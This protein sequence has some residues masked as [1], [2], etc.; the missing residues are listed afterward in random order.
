MSGTMG[1][2]VSLQLHTKEEAFFEAAR[3]GDV[4]R[5]REALAAH[6]NFDVDARGERGRTP[7]LAAARHGHAL[8]VELLLSVGAQPDSAN[9]SG[10]TPLMVRHVHASAAHAALY[11]LASWAC[12]ARPLSPPHRRAGGGFGRVRQVRGAA[13]RKWRDTHQ[14]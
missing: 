13:A 10:V 1:T 5:L 14:E 11:I 12:A 8:C 7:L 2:G 3:D 4:S 6:Q 9:D